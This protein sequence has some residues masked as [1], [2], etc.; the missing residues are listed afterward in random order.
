MANLPDVLLAPPAAPVSLVDISKSFGATRALD[1]VSLE[2]AAGEVHVLAGQNGAGK[3]TLIRILSGVCR[4]DRGCMLVDGKATPIQSPQDARAAGIATIHQELSLVGPMSVTDNL[5]MA[6]PAHPLSLLRP[7]QRRRRALRMLERLSLQLDVN[8][9]V[10]QLSLANRQLVEIARALGHDARVLVMDEPTS[11]L[12]E[13]ETQRLF[14]LIDTMREAGCAMLY[15]SHR[16][17]EIDRLADRITV[18]RDGKTVISS[19]AAKLPP[20][21]LIEHMLG[22]PTQIP[23]A[24]AL[25]VAEVALQVDELKLA[26]KLD[27]AQLT[28]H[29]GE[30]L[31]VAGLRGSGASLLPSALFGALPEVDGHIA[32]RGQLLRKHSPRDSIARGMVMLSGDR[33]TS[34]VHTS[35]VIHNA[36][37]SSL[38]RFS[39]GM[40]LQH[41]SELAAVRRT[42]DRLELVCPSLQAPVWQLSGGNQQKVALARAL[43]VE[44]EVLLLDEPTRGIDIGAKQDVYALIQQL[45]GAGVAM[46]VASS[47]SDELVRICHRVIV[48]SAGSIV[49]QL[50]GA[51]LTRERIVAASMTGR[52]A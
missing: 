39:R 45:A 7:A 9:P 40:W 24:T 5:L 10:E 15:I 20:D 50:R 33:S 52:A 47:E 8:V 6:E 3:S 18:L 35:S 48:L 43:L 21:Q 29:R 32:L 49:A 19:T 12:N 11:A 2:L 26:G 13:A 30:V 4:A 34:L 37:L 41:A 31:G 27:I 46:V 1:G 25:D 14:A 22:R 16:M 51:D 17:E 38:R 23:T 36:T 44:P 42:A 28:V